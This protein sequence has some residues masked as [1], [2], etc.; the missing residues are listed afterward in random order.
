MLVQNKRYGSAEVEYLFERYAV[1]ISHMRERAR[2][3]RFGLV[4]GAGCSRSLGLPNW[5]ELLDRLRHRPEVSGC[6]LVTAHDAVTLRSQLLFERFRS[7][8]TDQ[9]TRSRLNVSE[10]IETEVAWRE[11]VRECLYES[12]DQS[13][14]A[15]LERDKYLQE[16]LPVIRKSALTINYNFD[17]TLQRLLTE[18][19]R[20]NPNLKNVPRS[21][22]TVWS[23]RVQ[24]P[25]SE[26]TIYH[27]NGFL[28]YSKSGQTSEELVF[29][30]AAFADQLVDSVTGKYST[31]IDH[32]SQTT[33]LLIGLSLN[34]PT[35]RHVLRQNVSIYPGHVHYYVRYIRDGELT[36]D[37]RRV[38]EESNLTVHGLVTLFLNDSQIAALGKLIS[39]D[40]SEYANLAAEHSVPTNFRYFLVGAVGVGKTSSLRQLRSLRCHEE[41]PEELPL[42]MTKDPSTL[43]PTELKDIDHWVDHQLERKN[44]NLLNQPSGVDVIDRAPLDAF[45][46]VHANKWSMRAREISK[47]LSQESRARR[48][49]NGH[50]IRL[51]GD[52]KTIEVRARRVSREPTVA[53]IERQQSVLEVVYPSG[54]AVSVIDT[55]NLTSAQV[56]RAIV[57]IIHQKGIQQFDFGEVLDRIGDGSIAP[58]PAASSGS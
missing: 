49:C 16:W 36:D 39:A 42:S 9:S 28:P 44:S 58:P 17:D 13:H 18:D 57:R 6:D 56:V 25:R 10:E 22:S 31:L 45:A 38:E 23:S 52:A 14:Q 12:T 47:A 53:G 4:L 27:P 7:L 40:E 43:K 46:F 55:R 2:S 34:D 54:D 11:I 20:S 24:F 37:R 51:T 35:L 8:R 19:Q 33:C 15:V 3:Q 32:F 26:H 29:L 21:H 30:E 1:E 5:D 50:V 48:A 41:W